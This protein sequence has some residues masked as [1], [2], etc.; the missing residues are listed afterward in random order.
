MLFWHKVAKG[1]VPQNSG[2]RQIPIQKTASAEIFRPNTAGF[3]SMKMLSSVNFAE[4]ALYMCWLM[5]WIFVWIVRRAVYL[6]HWSPRGPVLCQVEDPKS[7]QYVFL[8]SW[9]T[10]DSTVCRSDEMGTDGKLSVCC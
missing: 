6:F 8:P 9:Y 1:T 4:E 3:L 10:G 5:D 7:S 2:G